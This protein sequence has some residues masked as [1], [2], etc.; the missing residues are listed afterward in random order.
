MHTHRVILA[1]PLA[2][3]AFVGCA[4]RHGSETPAPAKSTE[5]S[6]AAEATEA[7]AAAET[8]AEPAKKAAKSSG[9]HHAA[10]G[11]SPLEAIA[12]LS[13]GNA[14]FASGRRGRS[15]DATDDDDER[16]LTAKGQH[17]FAA[18][19]TCADSRL[20]PELIFDQSIGDIFVV[21]NAGNVAEPV[22]DGSMEYGVEHLGVRLIVVLG[23]SA[24]GAVKAVTG[25]TETL[26]GNLVAIQ[27]NMPGLQAYAAEQAKAGKDPVAAG[28]RRNATDQAT[29][30]LAES[31]ALR[32]AVAKG[33]LAIVPAVYDLESG[34]V[35][36]LAPVGGS[37]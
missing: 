9:G 16:T 36:F 26:P 13:A 18:V 8:K 5:R 28:V 12:R 32:A 3:A 2:L 21:R 14:R 34:L 24:C 31:E 11:P 6:H 33:T 1:L 7:P 29:A 23:H 30:M 15:A 17:P 25:T 19:L 4:E 35:E 22:G 27:K 10:A 20:P 37:N